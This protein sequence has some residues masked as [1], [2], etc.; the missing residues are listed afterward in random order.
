MGYAAHPPIATLVTVLKTDKRARIRKWAAKEL[1]LRGEP[2]SAEVVCAL[3]EALISDASA[4]V[5]QAALTALAAIDTSA[6]PAARMISVE[7]LLRWLSQPSRNKYV[8]AGKKLVV[9]LLYLQL[10]ATVLSPEISFVAGAVRGA[11]VFVARLPLGTGFALLLLMVGA[12]STLLWLLWPRG[13][14]S[15]RASSRP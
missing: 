4:E 13:R 9:V 15:S 11:Y 14:P 7:G 10:L 6:A 8:R 12:E 3:S 5:R 2:G 1:G